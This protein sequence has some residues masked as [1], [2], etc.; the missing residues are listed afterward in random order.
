M[1]AKKNAGSYY[2]NLLTKNPRAQKSGNRMSGH[3]DAPTGGLRAGSGG[4]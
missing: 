2:M 1:N 3:A 4:G